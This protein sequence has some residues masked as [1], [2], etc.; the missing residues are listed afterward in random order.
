MLSTIYSYAQAG[1]HISG[2]QVGHENLAWRTSRWPKLFAWM[3]KRLGA[4][5]HLEID[6]DCRGGCSPEELSS[7]LHSLGHNL[8]AE[9]E[10]LILNRTCRC[11]REYRRYD[12]SDCHSLTKPITARLQRFVMEESSCARVHTIWLSLDKVPSWRVHGPSLRH[13]CLRIP[14]STSVEHGG[15]PDEG[16][17]AKRLYK[18]KRMRG[19]HSKNLPKLQTLFLQGLR[20]P[21][22]LR[23]VNFRHSSTLKVINVHDCWIDDLA[24]PPACKVF[25]AA[26]SDFL[27][28]HMDC[29]REHPLV[30]RAK[31]VCL[32]FDLGE[33]ISDDDLLLSEETQLRQKYPMGIPDMFAAMRSFHLT[34]P[35]KDIRCG[36]CRS[37]DNFLTCFSNHA[38]EESGYA[39]VSVYHMRGLSRHWQHVN[40]RELLIEGDSL[41]ITIPALPKLKTLLVRCKGSVALDFVDADSLGQTITKL[42]VTGRRIFF[43][44]QQRKKLCTALRTR[45]LVLDGDW[46][47]CVAVY[48]SNDPAPTVAELLQQTMQGLACHCKGC[49]SCLGIGQ[50]MLSEED[51]DSD[52]EDLR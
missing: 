42:S 43:N 17:S 21:V 12:R 47:K 48:G 28:D 34:Q 41:G 23:G 8:N 49:P 36:Y 18:L 52:T 9:M 19:L 44:G 2:L 5:R 26:Q 13:I 7:L 35:N 40:L 1:E 51:S 31:H 3:G 4:T 29:A 50:S 33:Y 25:V 11:Q 39:D 27:I 30:S 38:C 20:E 46:D 10:T 45:D 32:P 22:E 24:L 6:I 37:W 16:P 15:W 14:P